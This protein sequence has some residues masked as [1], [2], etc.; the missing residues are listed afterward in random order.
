MVCVRVPEMSLLPPL[1][2]TTFLC[3]ATVDGDKITKAVSRVCTECIKVCEGVF[4]MQELRVPG[5][6]NKLLRTTIREHSPWKLK[7]VR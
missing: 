2:D 5:R 3:T 4:F 6:G 7:Q 1:R